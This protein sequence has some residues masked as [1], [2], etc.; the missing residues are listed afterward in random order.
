VGLW[1]VLDEEVENQS[2]S[3]R[4]RGGKKPTYRS[5]QKECKQ[6]FHFIAF[7]YLFAMT[8]YSI[9]VQNES[10]RRNFLKDAL[11]R[12]PLRYLF[13]LCGNTLRK[14]MLSTFLMRKAPY[15]NGAESEFRISTNFLFSGFVHRLDFS[16]DNSDLLLSTVLI[17]KNKVSVMMFLANSLV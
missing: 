12:Y 7:C 10:F 3:K 4:F 16:V 13:I 8:W 1:W 5:L 11:G 6:F 14:K 9:I 17:R 2:Y 15:K